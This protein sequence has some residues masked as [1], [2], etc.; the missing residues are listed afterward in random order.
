MTAGSPSAATSST[1][2]AGRLESAGPPH[3]EVRLVQLA[4]ARLSVASMSASERSLEPRW[5]MVTT[6][7][8]SFHCTGTPL[9]SVVVRT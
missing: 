8:R 5:S 6:M 7:Q 1:L 9:V 4:T 2:Y 3:W